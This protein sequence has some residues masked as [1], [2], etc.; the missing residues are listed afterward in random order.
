[1]RRGMLCAMAVLL[2][3]A[4]CGCGRQSSATIT[5]EEAAQ[6]VGTQDLEGSAKKLDAFFGESPDEVMQLWQEVLESGNGALRYALLC[7]NMRPY[8]LETMQ[9]GGNGWLMY[10]TDEIPDSVTYQAEGEEEDGDH[11]RWFAS[12]EVTRGDAISYHQLI[13][14]A[15]SGGYR[16]E[17]EFIQDEPI[18]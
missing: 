11:K 8:F 2:L 12:Y 7:E 13:V 1:M 10:D 4:L 18:E 16:V 3:I 5:G 9:D 14:I 15:E 17:S 6:M